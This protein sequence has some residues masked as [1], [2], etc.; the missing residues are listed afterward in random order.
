MADIALAKQ[1][2]GQPGMDALFTN[3]AKK[4]KTC[5]QPQG[6][7]QWGYDFSIEGTTRR[8]SSLDSNVV[9]TLK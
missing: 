1:L 3:V 8:S 5:N 4:N 9:G 6:S 2:F 7:F